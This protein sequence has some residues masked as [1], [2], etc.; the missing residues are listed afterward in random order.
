[1]KNISAVY[2][3]QKLF[4]CGIFQLKLIE[5]HRF[6]YRYNTIFFYLKMKIFS[7]EKSSLYGNNR[8]QT[9]FVDQ[10]IEKGREKLTTLAVIS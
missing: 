5:L 10:E 7:D 6:F 3:H 9:V 4:S 2:F 8:Q 1:M